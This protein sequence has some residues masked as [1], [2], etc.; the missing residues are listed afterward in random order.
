M[1]GSMNL[2]STGRQLRD[3]NG[4]LQE[5]SNVSSSWLRKTNWGPLLGGRI[6][7]TRRFPGMILCSIE[8]WKA[9]ILFSLVFVYDSIDSKTS[10]MK[11]KLL[12]LPKTAKT[13]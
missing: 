2:L 7:E 9:A 10:K 13:S 6:L 12:C 11:T 1:Y 4:S 5:F 3:F 8:W